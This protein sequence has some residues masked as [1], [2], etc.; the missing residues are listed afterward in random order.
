MSLARIGVRT[1]GGGGIGLGHVRR[2][3][4]LAEALRA[5]GAAVTFL[6]N[7]EGVAET[8]TAEGYAAQQ[9]SVDRDLAETLDAARRL[10]AHA[11]VADSYRFDAAYF[12][13]LR[14]D[15]RVTAIISDHAGEVPV[16]LVVNNTAGSET[17]PYRALPETRFLCGPQYVL[18]PPTFA[19][20]PHR[21]Y[22]V[23]IERVLITVGGADPHRLTPKLVCW[24]R[25]ALG[26]L[27]L[28]VVIG[29]Y[30]G[31]DVV[32]GVENENDALL[33]LHRT[34]SDIRALMLRADLALSGGGQ[35]LYELAATATPMVALVLADN[36]KENVT[37][38]SA[39]GVLVAAGRHDDPDLEERLRGEMRVQADD[40]ARRA[41]LGSAGRR[42]VDGR[43]AQRVADV[44]L[45]LIAERG[46]RGPREA[47]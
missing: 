43:G 32:R 39:A 24:T 5:R 14:G 8:I 44:V 36:Q 3:L 45:T 9:I 37:Q 30:F 25:S 7:G 15:G 35:T 40:P 19:A 46:P 42:L 31:D 20:E 41:A 10:N 34:P 2:C 6:V 4:S 22:R 21:V 17:W 29:P 26:A 18:L 13:R 23:P 12:R 47:L 11:I 38:L 1:E 16:D 33:V 28:D 27:L